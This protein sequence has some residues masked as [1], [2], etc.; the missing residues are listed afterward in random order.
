MTGHVKVLFEFEGTSSDEVEIESMWAI[1]CEEGYLIDNIPFYALG[2]AC[3]DLIQAH[4]DDAGMLRF[5]RVTVPSGHCTVRLWFAREE[6]VP[7]VREQLDSLG[8]SS[9]VSNLPRLVAVDIPPNVQYKRIKTFL[10]QGLASEVFEYEEACL[11]HG[12]KTDG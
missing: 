6:D 11:A 10:D 12:V 9:E 8:A 2:V 3:G 1:R 4:K 5:E 7:Q